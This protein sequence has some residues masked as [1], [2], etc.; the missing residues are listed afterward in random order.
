MCRV[1]L[2]IIIWC[3][4]PFVGIGQMQ[5]YWLSDK[6]DGW[7]QS[8][9]NR[10]ELLESPLGNS[11]HHK[12]N[13]STA[14]T[15]Y[16]TIPVPD[17]FYEN[18]I[19]TWNFS[20][21][22][23]YLPSAS[24]SWAFILA[25]NVSAVELSAQNPSTALILGVNYK[26]SDDLLKVW[27]QTI[28]TSGTKLIKQIAASSFSWEASIA[29]EYGYVQVTR[30]EGGEWSVDIAKSS[31][32][33]K[34]N[35]VNFAYNDDL[36]LSNLG[37]IYKYSAT[38]DQKLWFS[39]VSLDYTPTVFI[40]KD[41]EFSEQALGDTSS[42]TCNGSRTL[43]LSNFKVTDKA[44]GDDKPTVVKE[45]NII[46]DTSKLSNRQ[47]KLLIDSLTILSG[48]KQIPCNKSIIDS[49]VT[50]SL[51]V[52]DTISD[53]ESK[54]YSILT[55][56]PDSLQD[57]SEIH[58]Y[59]GS[60]PVVT[61][62]K[63]STC[64]VISSKTGRKIFIDALAGK[65]KPVSS[66]GVAVNGSLLT[67]EF[68]PVD[69]WGSVDLG[70]TKPMELICSNDLGSTLKFSSVTEGGK[71]SFVNIPI[72]GKTKLW[73]QVSGEGLEPYSQL[74]RVVNDTTSLA[75]NFSVD[76]LSVS[77]VNRDAEHA[78]EV[79]NFYIKDKGNDGLPTYIRNLVFEM[80]SSKAEPTKL[81]TG[82]VLTCDGKAEAARISMLDKNRV[83]VELMDDALA[84]KNGDSVKVS[85]NVFVNPAKI[86]DLG[87]LT[88]NLARV[89]ADSSGSLFGTS[90]PILANTLKF[91]VDADTLIF[92]K[93][94][95]AVK[96]AQAFEVDVKAC[97][98]Y[99]NTDVDYDGSCMLNFVGPQSIT[100]VQP[101]DGGYAKF[102]SQVVTKS[103]IYSV[104]ATSSGFNTK[105]EM[106][107][108]D[109]DSYLKPSLDINQSVLIESTSKFYDILKFKMV[110]TGETD[111]LS[112][113]VEQ[114]S[115]VFSDTVGL[116]LNSVYLDSVMFLVNGLPVSPKTMSVNANKRI[117]LKFSEGQF[118]VANKSTADIV[119][120]MKFAK[121]NPQPFVVEIPADGMVMQKASSALSV[122]CSYLIKSGVVRYRAIVG[123]LKPLGYPLLVKAGEPYSMAYH[124]FDING[125]RVVDF[126]G[127]IS[128]SS[129]NL[130]MGA[131][132]VTGGLI[133]IDS[134]KTLQQG[135]S[136]LNLTVNDSIK[137][138][139][140]FLSTPA[141]DSLIRYKASADSNN[142]W[143][144]SATGSFIHTGDEGRSFISYVLD[145]GVLART[146][147]WH[148]RFE[149][150]SKS[151]SS[152]NYCRFILWSDSK[153][154]AEFLLN[155]AVLSYK[156]IEG[157]ACLQ[158][159]NIVKGTVI[160]G[161]QPL[162]IPDI[163]GSL[164]DLWLLND[165]GK[166]MV[167]V[168]LNGVVEATFGGV[169][170]SSAVLVA[171]TGVEYTC[172][173][174]NVGK[175]ELHGVDIAVSAEHLRLVD[176]YFSS[177]GKVFI[178]MNMPLPMS[179]LALSVKDDKGTL[180]IPREI[181]VKGRNLSFVVDCENISK[182]MVKIIQGVDEKDIADSICIG[183]RAGL[184]RG[185]VVFSEIMAD[186]TPA[187]E[188]PEIEYLEIYN[189][190]DDTL[191]LS[192]W[193]V[194][195]NGKEYKCLQGTVSPYGYTTLTSSGGATLLSQYGNVA[196]LVGFNGL[197]NAGADV[198][199]VNPAGMVVASS[200]YKD[201][202]FTD[203]GVDGGVSLERLSVNS[204]EESKVA[205]GISENGRGG[206]PGAF[207][208]LGKDGDEDRIPILEQVRVDGANRIRLIFNEPI[209]VDSTL[210]LSANASNVGC[211]FEHDWRFPR[212]LTLTLSQDLIK[213][214][215]NMFTVSG[216]SDFGLNMFIGD[217]F[218]TVCSPVQKGELVVNEVLFNPD[219]LCSDYVEVVNISN[220][221][222]NISGLKLANR[223]SDGLVSDKK[224]ITADSFILKP[225]EFLLV[226]ST[227]DVIAVRYPVA[228]PERFVSIRS[229][230][231]YPNDKGCVVVLDSL[232]NIIDEF[233]YSE[234]MHFKMLPTA[235]G[236]S[237]ERISFNGN[238]WISASK[239]AA[240]GTPGTPNSQK[241]RQEILIQNEISLASD[242]ISPD[243]NGYNDFLSILYNLEKPGGMAD[244]EIFT[245]TGLSIKRLCRN[246]LLGTSGSIVWDG[247][248][249]DGLRAS[250][251]FYIAFIRITF[252]DKTSLTRKKVFSV[253]Y[254]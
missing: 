200:F 37:F 34:D 7:T 131:I 193:S 49:M 98:S 24:N 58:F 254:R 184:E 93:F 30:N 135:L 213:D 244:V 178:R 46:L 172:S 138:S 169:D 48:N 113:V 217:V 196:T 211:S 51:A 103:G 21:K 101:F 81:L 204:T 168:A 84:V 134:I 118:E 212:F 88:F 2:G 177:R 23:G 155:A 205:W 80:E 194:W 47:F 149:L 90:A 116:K 124:L 94:S 68:C 136:M 202:F 91:K 242:I 32:N 153:P 110:D 151:Y 12:F 167:A 171:A 102:V 219:G 165:D 187:K 26:G 141:V 157:K 82:V 154:S 108:A 209:I 240:Y 35:V 4:L 133:G 144:K 236:V 114:L 38:A 55:T 229:M 160:S 41:S 145:S 158:F 5:S 126:K 70:Y 203:K 71:V 216:I 238:Q 36:P 245:S 239:E 241:Q 175:F 197:P 198:V 195:V 237:L 170:F 224:I 189:M 105:K 87:M 129:L 18:G 1:L 107:V 128:P 146:A 20:V 127:A 152:Q 179:N 78:R 97:D 226:C 95:N 59:F 11:I 50:V 112:T 63:F 188:L 137:V 199:L 17:I 228:R 214:V 67:M 246:E 33:P 52:A 221:P 65:I 121:G 74:V 66:Y 40:D 31:D 173:I 247:I 183:V 222:V 220:H 123:C 89:V 29:L 190:V 86:P 13:N 64:E 100:N 53:G 253:A 156:K 76:T 39:D 147:Q 119:V 230:P 45:F 14:A 191:D 185:D 225:D 54:A 122:V 60:M 182:L 174:S 117:V 8:P 218:A 201:I 130:E 140:K 106:V 132:T 150:N 251:G 159:E 42:F 223:S 125:S 227:P 22:H 9:D 44:S 249:D 56:F 61:D 248:T 231:S 75:C 186:P 243:N 164:C 120:K 43:C 62:S 77:I 83:S 139:N 250:R 27:E 99:R 72:K 96:P 85:L 142:G 163:D 161:S 19:L 111:T 180:Y 25:S 252:D 104:N 232:D 192:S 73:I 234:S 166:W 109:D 210:S 79:S 16:I 176:G 162:Y 148:Y 69:C 233:A 235:K 92:S 181:Q 6:L 57:S 143:K 10:W 28:S 3:S 215:V 206:T 208:S 115:L 15:D 207:N